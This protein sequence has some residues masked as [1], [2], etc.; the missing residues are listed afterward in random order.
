MSLGEV[1]GGLLIRE[2]HRFVAAHAAAVVAG[3]HVPGL[4]RLDPV[5]RLRFVPVLGP[6]HVVDINGDDVL[7]LLGQH[8]E[9][10]R[11]ADRAE[12]DRLAAAA[13]EDLPLGAAMLEHAHRAEIGDGSRGG[14]LRR[15]F[16]SAGYVLLATGESKRKK[17]RGKRRRCCSPHHGCFLAKMRVAKAKGTT[18]QAA[19]AAIS[20]PRPNCS[21][22]ASPDMPA[23]TLAFDM[24]ARL[25]KR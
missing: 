12:P 20:T 24:P 21:C 13:P 5:A 15:R 19:S 4:A 22:S 17:C 7:R 11:V 14:F 9:S 3:D 25:M 8:G 18:T 1:A 2:R 23:K 10:D 6:R 16:R